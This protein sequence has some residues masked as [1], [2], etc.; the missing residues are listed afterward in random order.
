[1]NPQTDEPSGRDQS[2]PSGLLGYLMIAGA[3]ILAVWNFADTERPSNKN[4]PTTNA[5]A[6]RNDAVHSPISN[7]ENKQVTGNDSDQLFV[8]S[9]F[10][11]T[12][13]TDTSYHFSERKWDEFLREYPKRI[14]EK[15]E[16]SRVDESSTSRSK[17][18]PNTASERRTGHAAL[19]APETRAV[20]ER[21]ALY[22]AGVKATTVAPESIVGFR[23]ADYGIETR[24]W[25][26]FSTIQQFDMLYLYAERAVPGSGERM[27]ALLARASAQQYD[28]AKY[29]PA[30]K[31]HLELEASLKDKELR[32]EAPTPPISSTKLS[33]EDVSKIE[34]LDKYLN[35][36]KL[37]GAAEVMQR[38]FPLS[39][40]EAAELLVATGSLP[41]AIE[42]QLATLGPSGRTGWFD[43]VTLDLS[44]KY[45]V[46]LREPSLQAEA[47]VAKIEK[48][49]V[50][51]AAK[52]VP[53][54]EI[55]TVKPKEPIKPLRRPLRR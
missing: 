27:L 39:A 47:V 21:C 37:G 19:S 44:L 2:A 30:L 1:M 22:L 9:L 53:V 29:D 13:G 5:V 25:D 51:K 34:A 50:S 6:P 46:V 12:T 7:D 28:G 38:Y 40:T 48:V 26:S 16:T 55:P 3:L 18:T 43:V 31:K 24:V 42:Q 45:P 20:I 32:F 8:L 15:S 10:D 23:H 36:R 54:S 33:V 49:K 11:S 41:K 52:K 4:A 17:L 35:G 14:D